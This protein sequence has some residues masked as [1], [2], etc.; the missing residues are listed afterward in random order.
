MTAPERT[1]A[2]LA[3]YERHT[4]RFLMVRGE[5]PIADGGHW[6]FVG[7]GIEPGEEPLEA[8]ARETEE[9]I[10]LSLQG[11]TIYEVGTVVWQLPDRHGKPYTNKWLL[12]FSML[13]HELP[14]STPQTTS[15]MDIVA[16]TRNPHVSSLAKTSIRLIEFRRTIHQARLDQRSHLRVVR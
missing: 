11:K 16:A 5:R 6:S 7:G 10:G 4:E 8:L 3:L 9:E 12:Y 15:Y 2:K 1:A 14:P 13:G